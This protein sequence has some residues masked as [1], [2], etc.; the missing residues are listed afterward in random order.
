MPIR[1]ALLSVYDKT[2]ILDF[3]REL[4]ALGVKIVSTGGTAK[5]LEEGGLSII[6][7]DQVTGFPEMMHGRVK[8]LHPNIHAGILADRDVP[9]HIA[10]LEKHQIEPIDLVCVNLYPFV[11]VTSN[12]NC[13]LA[14]AIENIDIGGPTMVRAACKNHKH[15]LIVTSPDQYKFILEKIKN[16]KIDSETRRMLAHVAFRMTAE[17]DIHIQEYLAGQLKRPS[18]DSIFPKKLLSAYKK[19]LDL[20]YGE[21]PHQKA[22]LYIDTKSV[23]TGWGNITQVSGKELSFNNIVDANAALELVMEFTDKPAVC[24]IKH[25]NPSGT[26]MNDDLV[27]AYRRAYLGD[28]NAAMGGIIAVNRPIQPDLAEAIVDS[29]A[30]WGKT[31][32]ANAFF[33]E[34]IIAPKFTPEALKILTT[35]KPWGQEVRLLEVQDWIT[36]RDREGAGISESSQAYWDIKR[37][38]GGLLAQ[39]RDDASLNEDQWKIVGSTKPTNQQMNDLRFAWLVCKH[40]KS[41]AI[42]L[43]KDATLLAAGAGQMSRIMSAKLSCE[44]AGGQTKGSVMASDA[45]FPFRD[46]IDQADK[47]GITAVIE[48]GGSKRDEEV[49]QAANEHKIVLI[50]TGTRHFKH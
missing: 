38:R 28:P 34:I 10:A 23:P 14:D 13:T 12:P 41:N 45:F 47:V 29:L 17:Y 15:V 31:A 50:F 5:L 20:R 1:T 21:N 7:V 49:I 36:S 18:E 42:V 40:V 26:A 24:I 35:R 6:P 48:P 11:K 4:S 19:T 39:T 25:T 27:E 46:S 37:I 30:R 9:E 16:G 2:G 33:A 44:I 22:A 32:G 3:A 43:A 8:T